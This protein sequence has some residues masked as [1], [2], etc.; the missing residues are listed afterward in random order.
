M[1]Y[2]HPLLAHKAG[3]EYEIAFV[4]GRQ[5]YLFTVAAHFEN[6]YDP[7]TRPAAHR[8]WRDGWFDAHTKTPK[9]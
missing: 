6:P 8:G 7:T 3:Q 9:R 4:L 2:A 1:A 5:A